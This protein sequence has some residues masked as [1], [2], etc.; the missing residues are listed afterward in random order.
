VSKLTT[1]FACICTSAYSVGITR[2][3]TYRYTAGASYNCFFSK[4]AE[5]GIEDKIIKDTCKEMLV[6]KETKM[7]MES[8]KAYHHIS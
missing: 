1:L 6:E 4:L 8:W 2:I 3:I 5:M 7:E